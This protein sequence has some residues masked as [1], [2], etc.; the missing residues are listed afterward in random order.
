MSRLDEMNDSPCH[1]Y[2]PLR[3]SYQA[4][5]DKI[6]NGRTGFIMAAAEYATSCDPGSIYETAK[7]PQRD[8]GSIYETAKVPQ[9]AYVR[10]RR[11]AQP[12]NI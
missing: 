8:P 2:S 7:V 11:P 1:L 12:K 10:C 3:L 4:N 6:E 5:H 9:R